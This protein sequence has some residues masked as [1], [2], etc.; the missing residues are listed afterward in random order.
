MQ[1]KSFEMKMIL[2]SYYAKDKKRQHSIDLSPIIMLKG[3]QTRFEIR[4]QIIKKSQGGC[5]PFQQNY[6]R[7]LFRKPRLGCTKKTQARFPTFLIHKS[8]PIAYVFFFMFR[9]GPLSQML[10]RKIIYFKFKPMV[11]NISKRTKIWISGGAKLWSNSDK[12]GKYKS[13]VFNLI[14]WVPA[15]RPI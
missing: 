10:K 8:K 9:K 3:F 2:I 6:S 11:H 4:I 5:W 15:A 1:N 13:G 12:T 14:K 7:P